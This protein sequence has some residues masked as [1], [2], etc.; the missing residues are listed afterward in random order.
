MDKIDIINSA[1][2]DVGNFV[3][4]V[5]GFTITLFTVLY[6]FILN[7]REL[8]NEISDSI[9]RGTG[10]PDPLLHQRST[11]AK[12]IITRLKRLNC[13]LIAIIITTFVVYVLCMSAKYLIDEF[14]YKTILIIIV[15]VIA[16]IVVIYV[17][18]MLILTI[19][20]YIKNTRI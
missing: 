14:N 5:F 12:R 17:F 19:K 3:L 11:N 20:D 2:S 13:H 8:L 7:K 16:I 6:S 4:V 15:G 18:I 1:L 9:K 10:T